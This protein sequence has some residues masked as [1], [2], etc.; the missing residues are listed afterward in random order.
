MYEDIGIAAHLV[1]LFEI[2][3]RE[4]GLTRKQSFVDLG[5]GNGFLVHLLNC[6]GYGNI[7]RSY[8]MR[9]LVLTV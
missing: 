7:R 2:D 6:E 9:E 5:C 8:Q 4:R 1:C 3:A